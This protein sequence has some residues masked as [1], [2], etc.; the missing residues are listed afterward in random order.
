MKC[1]FKNCS[2]EA[3]QQFRNV[4]ACEFNCCDDHSKFWQTPTIEIIPATV[5]VA[6]DTAEEVTKW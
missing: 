4:N 5:S 1:C 6:S 2:K 3:T